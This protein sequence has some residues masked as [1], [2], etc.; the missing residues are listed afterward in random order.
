MDRVEVRGLDHCRHCDPL[1]LLNEFSGLMKK[2][3]KE[4]KKA[5]EVYRGHVCA[6]VEQFRK[7]PLSH[8]ERRYLTRKEFLPNAVRQEVVEV[9][10]D[11]LQAHC[12]NVPDLFVFQAD[13]NAQARALWYTYATY[14]EKDPA[15]AAKKKTKTGEEV[16]DPHGEGKSVFEVDVRVLQPNVHVVAEALV[17]YLHESGQ[18]MFPAGAFEAL[19]RA[20]APG[21]AEAA[22]KAALQ[23]LLK[24]VSAV[25]V[26]VLLRLTTLANAL[27]EAAR[28]EMEAQVGPAVL[29]VP[30]GSVEQ[31]RNTAGIRAEAFGLLRREVGALPAQYVPSPHRLGQARHFALPERLK[32]SEWELLLSIGEAPRHFKN[33]E[34]VV[35]EHTLQ[36]HLYR[37]TSGSFSVFVGEARVGELIALDWFGEA[38]FLGNHFSHARVV[39]DRKGG[40]VIALPYGKL[41]AVLLSR[42][43]LARKF[44]SHVALESASRLNVAM[45]M[46]SQSSTAKVRAASFF[47][48]LLEI[49][50]HLFCRTLLLIRILR[51]WSIRCAKPMPRATA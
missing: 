48:V 12:Q 49:F 46:A 8:S 21:S 24:D 25:N 34:T 30:G 28:R 51:W 22:K 18:A 7:T 38:A 15:A 27:P 19:L 11:Y 29:R 47:F 31:D 4:E 6:A 40:S 32:E 37:I 2:A 36:G 13:E 39:A 16:F 43:D 35:H 41:S 1:T 20:F 44:Y 10:A 23:T 3:T 50:A 9:L 33:G 26:N 17:L 14:S 42:P 5:R 45:I